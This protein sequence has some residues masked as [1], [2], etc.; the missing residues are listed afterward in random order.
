MLHTKDY[1]EKDMFQTIVGV[2]TLIM[3]VFWIKSVI[4]SKRVKEKQEEL[5]KLHE[6]EEVLDIEEQI[7]DREVA[8]AKRKKD[9][10]AKKEHK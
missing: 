3:F 2:L 1:K 9:I 7:V 10:N 4:K 5:A 6:D 8:L